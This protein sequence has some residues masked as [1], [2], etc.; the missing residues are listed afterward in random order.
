MKYLLSILL[1]AGT[2]SMNAQDY[3]NA[4]GIR[5]GSNSGLTFKHFLN[6]TIAVEGILSTKYSGYIVTGLVEKHKPLDIA[7]LHMTNLSFFYG[8][9]GHFG[10]FRDNHLVPDY[11]GS[12]TTLGI[13]FI[14]G[15]EYQFDAIPFN[16]SLD[17][18]PFWSLNSYY[19]R[20]SSFFDGALSVRY[21]I[22]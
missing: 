20:A 7:T 1:L 15:L 6:P 8:V 17:V 21:I 12:F 10:S 5:G 18:M 19:S 9:G 4:I 16:I 14:G 3:T 22:N 13:N 11:N 2:L